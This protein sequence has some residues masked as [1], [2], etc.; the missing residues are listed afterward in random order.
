MFQELQM[1]DVFRKELQKNFCAMKYMWELTDYDR[2]IIVEEARTITDE[3]EVKEFV[4]KL[5]DAL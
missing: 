4:K 3:K 1:P 5:A 2:L